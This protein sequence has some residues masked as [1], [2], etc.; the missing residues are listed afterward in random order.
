MLSDKPR[1]KIRYGTKLAV[2]FAPAD[3]E[4]IPFVTDRRVRRRL[5][6]GARVFCLVLC[7]FWAPHPVAAATVHELLEQGD[8]LTPAAQL[9]R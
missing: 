8:R 2:S 7:V 3:V 5:R 4:R 6:V 9:G 1:K